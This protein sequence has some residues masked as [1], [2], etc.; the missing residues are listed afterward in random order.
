M[1][2]DLKKCFVEF[3]GTFFLCFTILCC[4]LLPVNPVLVPIAIGLVLAV[5][6]YAGGPISGGHYNPAVSLAIFLIGRMGTK[7]TTLYCIFQMFGAIYAALMAFLLSPAFV[8]VTANN[9]A[10][11]PLIVGEIVFT[12]LLIY[13]VIFTA[14]SKRI[15][16]NQYFGIAIGTSVMVGVAAIGS[17][18]LAALNPAVAFTVGIMGIATWKTVVITIVANIAASFIACGLFK[19]LSLDDIEKVEV[20]GIDEFIRK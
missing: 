11:I 14:V 15:Q 8:T 18:A 3:F 17:I 19:L 2:S 7:K 1:T 20:V 16:G 9:F 5:L 12:T 13:T 10:K 4:I 6:V